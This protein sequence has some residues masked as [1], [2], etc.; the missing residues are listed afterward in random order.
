[1]W[2]AATHLNL[3]HG[4]V[5]QRAERPGVGAPARALRQMSTE[6]CKQYARFCTVCCLGAWGPLRVLHSEQGCCSEPVVWP[7]R[8]P[9]PAPPPEPGPTGVAA[10]GSCG[11]VGKL[12]N[13]TAGEAGGRAPWHRTTTISAPRQNWIILTTFSTSCRSA[14]VRIR[15]NRAST[16][17]WVKVG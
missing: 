13:P 9:R 2:H 3:V 17:S 16:S 14:G 7:Q 5:K 15:L 10:G 4:W 6:K 11:R 12:L 1:M 8:P